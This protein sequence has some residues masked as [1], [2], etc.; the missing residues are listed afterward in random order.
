[1]KP[2]CDLCG[3]RHESYQGHVF[4]TNRASVAN[5]AVVNAVVNKKKNPDRHKDKEGRKKY[6]RDMRKRRS[7]TT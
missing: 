1:L 5:A 6:L 3:S 7:A 2:L 4:A